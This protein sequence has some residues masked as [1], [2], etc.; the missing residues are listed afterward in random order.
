MIKKYKITI[1]KTEEGYE[2]TLSQLWFTFIWPF[3]IDEVGMPG[4]PAN[5]RY[6]VGKWK[7]EYNVIKVKDFT[8]EF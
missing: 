3:W 8:G 5:I 1:R 4:L 7:S 2:V 6:Y